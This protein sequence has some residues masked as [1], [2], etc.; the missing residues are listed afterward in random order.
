MATHQ[1]LIQWQVTGGNQNGIKVTPVPADWSGLHCAAGRVR[2]KKMLEMEP[3]GVVAFP[4]GNGT[5]NMISISRKAGVPVWE[6][7]S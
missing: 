4:G 3:D 2:N 7:H 6:I 5:K 1:A